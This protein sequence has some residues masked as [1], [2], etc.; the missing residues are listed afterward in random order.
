MPKMACRCC[1]YWRFVEPCAS[2]RSCRYMGWTRAVSLLSCGAALFPQSR[3][4]GG[5]R[6]A[7]RRGDGVRCGSRRLSQ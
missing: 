1:R 7:A 5:L 3:L 4:P 2:T 6:A